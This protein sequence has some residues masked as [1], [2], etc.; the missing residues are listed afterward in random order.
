M[1]FLK[2]DSDTL[3]AIGKASVM[4]LHMVTGTLVGGVIGWFLDDWL[5]TSPWLF[6]LFFIFGVAAGFLNVLKDLK[7]LLKAQERSTENKKEKQ[8]TEQ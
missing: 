4:G 5:G 8:E 2:L 6:L 7:I 1:S 3:T